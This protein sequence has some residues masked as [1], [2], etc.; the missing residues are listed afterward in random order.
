MQT[1][2]YMVYLPILITFFR[3]GQL[4]TFAKQLGMFMVP[5]L[6]WYLIARFMSVP[7]AAELR[8]LW[9]SRMQRARSRAGPVPIGPIDAAAPTV[10]ARRA[11]TRQML[12]AAV[13]RRCEALGQSQAGPATGG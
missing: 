11:A 3:D 1:V 10:A 8:A 6:V 2:S 12:P 5:I 9:R 4:L 13:L 7:T